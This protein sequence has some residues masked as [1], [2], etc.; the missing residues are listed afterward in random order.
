M[1][2]EE[3]VLE[4]AR[5]LVASGYAPAAIRNADIQKAVGGSFR[6][7]A[8][9]L[10]RWKDQAEREERGAGRGVTREPLPEVLAQTLMRLGQTFWAEVTAS[11]QET[12]VTA[13]AAAKEEITQAH[14]AADEVVEA[15]RGMEA[16]KERLAT[17]VTA[18]E[19]ERS[20][21]REQVL[22]L[23]ADVARAEERHRAAAEELER[24]RAELSALRMRLDESQKAETAARVEAAEWKGRA[25]RTDKG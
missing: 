21:N 7:I 13:Q 10:R 9:A 19:N 1:D 22:T 11:A 5:A 8:P 16:E 12:I 15:L 2:I 4:A 20:Q 24:T 25:E 6:D 23:T 14:A 17:Q 3:R 18:L